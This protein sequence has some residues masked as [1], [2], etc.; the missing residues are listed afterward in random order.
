MEINFNAEERE[1]KVL[2]EEYRRLMQR[3]YPT[4]LHWTHY[5]LAEHSDIEDPEAWKRF[6]LDPR[7]QGWLD[8]ELSIHIKSQVFKL[9]ED[10]DSNRSTAV[11]Q[12]LNSFLNFL[13]KRQVDPA[14]MGPAYIYT[15]V[16]LTT[17]EQYASN[18]RILTHNPMEEAM[19]K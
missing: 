4:I 19:M 16:P 11:V 1:K 3:Y 12:T 18:V 17:D 7:I 8:E 13:E 2:L 10:S 14:N 5:D 9:V 6:I 15:F